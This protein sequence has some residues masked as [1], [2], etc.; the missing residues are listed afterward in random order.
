MLSTP[1]FSELARIFPDAELH[2]LT[3]PAAASLVK[4]HP[5]LTAVHT[6]DKRKSERGLKGIW[7]M[8]RRLRSERFTHAFCLHKSHRTAAVM[9]LSG[10][11]QR[12][13]FREANWSWVYTQR[14]TRKEYAHE[15]QRNLAV[16]KPLGVD[17][18]AFVG[19]MQLGVGPEDE[20]RAGE[21]L[22]P[23]EADAIIAVAPGSVWATKR[24]TTAGFAEVSAY[25]IEKR[26][27][28]VLI[29]GPDDR[30]AAEEIEAL[31]GSSSLLNLVGACGLSVS[32]G[33]LRRAALLVTNDSAPLHIAAAVG[34]PVVAVFCATVP[35][36]GFGP[37]GVP[38]VVLGVE[39]LTCRPCGSHGGNTCPTGTHACQLQVQATAVIEAANRLLEA[40]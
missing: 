23:V 33:I 40:Q 31:V 7:Q 16:L 29:G 17:P 2:V 8:A 39:G 4:S 18:A 22:Q 19:T 12:Y 35:E 5:L 32:A 24:W 36:F 37:W 20:H 13:G 14:S 15:V 10:I 9:L 6:F 38:N 26:Y 11:A 3:T 28:V 30:K 25:F 21:L 1:V 27:A 34:T